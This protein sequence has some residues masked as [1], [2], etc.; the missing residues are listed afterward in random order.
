MEDGPAML[1]SLALPRKHR[2]EVKSQTLL[3]DLIC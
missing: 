2:G 1:L 3:P